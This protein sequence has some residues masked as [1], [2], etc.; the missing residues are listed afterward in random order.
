MF[1]RRASACVFEFFQ[2]SERG[3][4][5]PGVSRPKH[6]SCRPVFGVLDS[7]VVDADERLDQAVA[8][9]GDFAERQPTLVE[10]TVAQAFLT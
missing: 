1:R 2:S 4:S 5:Q 9:F 10:L 8:D 7:T 3:P 6:V